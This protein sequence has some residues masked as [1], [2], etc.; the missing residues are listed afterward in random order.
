MKKPEIITS[1]SGV[2]FRL[3]R[4]HIQELDVADGKPWR[5][6]T[7][8]AVRE[9]LAGA[10]YTEAR[11]LRRMGIA[12][13]GDVRF[14]ANFYGRCIGCMKFRGVSLRRL[15]AWAKEK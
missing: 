7:R 4:T 2:R 9:S 6:A 3:T 5:A 15:K 11:Y 14:Y 12:D 8:A 13:K 1:T 10:E